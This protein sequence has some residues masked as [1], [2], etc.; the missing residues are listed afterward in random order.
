MVTGIISAT[1]CVALVGLFIGIFLGVAGEKFKVEVDPRE[2]EIT[3]TLPGNNCGGCGF[4][5]CAS[6]AAAIVAGDAPVNACPVGGNAVA[7]KVAAIMGQ[8]VSDSA[9]KVAFVK[10]AGDC[11]KAG[12][13]F[14]Y[15]GQQSCRMQAKLPSGGAKKCSYGCLGGGDCVNA[16]QFGAIKIVNG[17][18]V[19]DENK[20]TAC[21]A[22]AAACPKKLIEIVP[23]ESRVRVCCSSKDKGPVVMKACT[24]GCIGCK[25]CEKN[26][27]EGA[28]TVEDFHAHIDYAKCTQCGLCASKCPKKSIS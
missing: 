25:M 2:E 27:P 28:I 12:V 20:C 24:V 4:A 22:C 11:D 9:K 23:Y 26:C 8:E 21:G 15:T 6:L 17:I 18:A 3:G 14:K 16:C 1:L 10:C 13:N 19:V 5:G 7:Q